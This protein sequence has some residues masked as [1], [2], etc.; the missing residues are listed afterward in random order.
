LTT[1]HPATEAS[2]KK[3][4]TLIFLLG[5][6]F[7]SS[8]DVAAT[9]RCAPDNGG[10]Q[11]PAGFCASVF[12][13][14]LGTARHM[15][16]NNNGDVYVALQSEH[17][18]GAIAALRDTD[19]DGKADIVKYLGVAG[20]TTGI[21]IHN[22]YLYF[23]TPTEVFRYKL[24]P[25]Q[26]VPQSAPQLVVGGFPEQD[27]HSAKSIAF[28]AVGH[29][30]V[31]VGA[32]S[33]SC[34]REDRSSGSP[35]IRPCPLLAQHGGIWEFDADRVGQ[36]FMHD[37]KH[38]ATGIR[39]AVAITWHDGLYVL[40]MGRDQLHEDWPKLYSA[41]QGSELPAEEFLHVHAGDDF[42]WPYCYYDQLQKKRM[43][44][45]EYGG[46]GKMQGDCAKYPAPIA[47][48]PGHWAPESVLF[49]TGKQF[50]AD[51]RDGA[52]IAFHG[53][54]NRTPVQ[55]G[56]KV[57]FVP[58]RGETASGD[59]Q[60]FADGFAATGKITSPNAARYRPMGLAQGPDGALYIDD[61]QHGRVWRVIH[62]N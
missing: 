40:Q 2:V 24:S 12:A 59:A 10:I 18:R 44:E 61:S 21:G 39:N 27:E 54:W 16:V 43:L 31:N 37:G 60:V 48:F 7:A 17:D 38:Y 23:A 30:Y 41:E 3:L 55:A 15:T 50:P 47:A 46:N 42:G 1:R 51:W 35:G 57:M 20:G 22:G 6:V 25:G 26:L 29:L 8:N 33:N 28:D 56:Y 36:D 19:G 13:D 9:F 4:F 52:F 58:F 62:Q 34:Q 45:P 53:S 49:Y 32:P 5:C 11:L 14:N